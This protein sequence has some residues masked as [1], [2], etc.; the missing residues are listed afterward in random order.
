MLE[1]GFK[2]R[3]FDFGTY[4]LWMTCEQNSLKRNLGKRDF[5][6]SQQFANQ[7]N[8]AVSVKWRMH[9]REQREGL[10]FIEKYAS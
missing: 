2:S 1:L 9:F 4:A 3:P 10:D 6:P 8:I 7:G 5:F